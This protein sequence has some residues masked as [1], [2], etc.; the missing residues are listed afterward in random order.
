MT[1]RADVGHFLPASEPQK[2]T[3]FDGWPATKRVRRRLMALLYRLPDTGLFGLTPL[4]SHLL[5][6]GF[7]AAGT[8]LLQLML[9][10]GLPDARRFGREVGGW[11]AA[12]YT[13]RNHPVVISKVPHDVFR[14]PALRDFYAG[15]RARL[16]VLLML[17]DP[18][19]LL[20]ARRPRTGCGPAGCGGHANE[21]GVD[22]YCLTPE[23]WRRYWVAFCKNR[24]QPDTLV[25]RYEDLVA[26][27]ADE[28]RR[29]ERF[30]GRAMAVPFADCMKVD[31]PDFDGTALRGRRP[32]DASRVAR[33]RD[34]A[35]A[36]RL[37]E[38]LHHLPE[39]PAAVADLG[40]ASDTAWA[41]R[42]RAGPALSAGTPANT[43]RAGSDSQAARPCPMRTAPADVAGAAAVAIPSSA[44]AP[45]T[46]H[47]TALRPGVT[48]TPS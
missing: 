1:L 44:V 30:I 25:V 42:F 29:I 9:E 13:W 7:P 46:A 21:A 15:R 35:H 11:R 6:C 22:D 19:D 33:W 8:T 16:Q 31:R 17:R 5:I 28:Q 38:V 43:C 4:Q 14:L 45:G 18:R 20:T 40:Y 10:N 48:M 34:P 47:V 26:D 2:G 37:A 39:L 3:I 32:V 23:Q 24:P 27:V 12:T 36:A 41:D